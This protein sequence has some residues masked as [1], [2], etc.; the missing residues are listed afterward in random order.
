MRSL[1][2]GW[3]MMVDGLRRLGWPS[4]QRLV[5]GRWWDGDVRTRV[6]GEGLA[7]RWDLEIRRV[8][9]SFDFTTHLYS[10]LYR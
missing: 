5:D 9:P 8:T 10:T 2:V 6:G 4:N 3:V 7:I 1:V